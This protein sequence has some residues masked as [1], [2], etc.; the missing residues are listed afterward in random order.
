M[1]QT[2][3]LH[4]LLRES[5]SNG[6]RHLV[7][8]P[9]GAAV[10]DGIER[11]LRDSDG[12][13]VLLDFTEVELMDLS[14]ADEVVAKLLLGDSGALCHLVL[15]NLREDQLEAVDHVLRHHRLAVAAKP[16]ADA[17]PDVLGWVDEDARQVFGYMLR[18][19]G[20]TVETVARELGWTPTRAEQALGT[21][22]ARRLMLVDRDAFLPLPLA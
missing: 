1:I 19:G 7:T 17:E 4:H 8:R 16:S 14:C 5:G 9:T 11:A 20:G 18:C 6:S 10:R 15:C 21:L 3:R 2:I 22:A 13:T 12:A